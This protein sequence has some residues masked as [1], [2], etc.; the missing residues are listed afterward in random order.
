MSLWNSLIIYSFISGDIQDANSN[1][2]SLCAK[3]PPPYFPGLDF[4]PI[5]LVLLIVIP[6]A[7]KL[8]IGTFS[9]LDSTLLDCIVNGS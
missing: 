2:I 7:I 4:I 3:V 6:I 9:S 5:A 8:I 1:A